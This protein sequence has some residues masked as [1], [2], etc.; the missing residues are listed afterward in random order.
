VADLLQTFAGFERRALDLYRHLASVFAEHPTAGKIW[1]A[2][3]DAEAGH[4]AMLRLAE[5]RLPAGATAAEGPT[6]FDESGLAKWESRIEQLDRTGRE[7]GITLQEAA[8]ITLT[9]ELEELPGLLA[10]LSSLPQPARRLTAAGFTE[11]AKEHLH[12]VREL[13][14]A[15]GRESLLPEVSRLEE[16][17]ASLRL[18]AGG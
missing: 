2:M 4:F 17:M 6:G 7:A 18:L 12:C 9:W 3:S 5:D 11:G 10:L 13:L 14:K 8:E 1:R 15:A 16:L